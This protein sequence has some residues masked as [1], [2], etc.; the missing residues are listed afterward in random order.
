MSDE[1]SLALPASRVGPDSG[2][3]RLAQ[4][5]Q[6]QG[7]NL[8]VYT[9]EQ[10]ELLKRTVCRGTTDDEFALFVQVA[11]RTGLDPFARQIHAVKRWDSRENREVMAIQTGIDGYR[12]VAQR[13]GAFGG[14]DDFEYGPE[15][16]D[17]HPAWARAT[18]YRIIGGQRV[19]ITRTARWPEFAATYYD[20]KSQ[21]HK[22][23]PLWARMPY[24]ML[25]KCAE[26]QA[27]RAAF[28]AELSGVYTH[29][30]MG[31][32]SNEVIDP[33]PV[34]PPTR[35]E[36]EPPQ[37]PSL[38]REAIFRSLEQPEVRVVAREAALARGLKGRRKSQWSDED[39]VAVRDA[40]FQPAPP[41][42]PD[43]PFTDEE[44]GPG[45]PMR[46]PGEE[47]LPFGGA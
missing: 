40:V 9:R 45:V 11:S 46:E 8:S 6:R 43:A 24:L 19:A 39:L 35:P 13:S 42:D 34:M 5:A 28:P 10:V 47:D 27:L 23:T 3:R 36:P 2:E 12:V 30:E 44:V 16:P 41:L 37:G 33:E 14:S 25:G 15:D 31:Q 18:V 1:K 4:A 21:Q 20:R 7:A 22:L 29:E 38:D 32:A 17:G 26:S